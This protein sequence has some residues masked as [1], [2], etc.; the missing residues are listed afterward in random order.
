M[1]L[2]PS[3][4]TETKLPHGGCNVYSPKTSVTYVYD[5]DIRVVTDGWIQCNFDITNRIEH[6]SINTNGWAEYIPRGLWPSPESPDQ[7][8]SPKMSKSAKKPQ[9]PQSVLSVAPSSGISD[10]GVPEY[11]VRFLE[12]SF[13]LCTQHIHANLP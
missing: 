5:N 13:N 1:R 7:K 4:C 8:Q 12:V 11:L 6:L 2:E 9:K 10:Y 3:R